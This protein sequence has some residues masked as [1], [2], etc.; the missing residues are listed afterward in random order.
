LLAAL[1]TVLP[2]PL[3][4][5]PTSPTALRTASTFA[6]LLEEPLPLLELRGLLLDL[7]FA[8]EAF[9]FADFAA[10]GFADD[11]G[12]EAVF[13]FDFDAGFDADERFVLVFV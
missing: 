13:D 7:G 8:F 4:L 12:F 11:F 10:F 1:P 5:S 9:D 6:C 3:A 2:A